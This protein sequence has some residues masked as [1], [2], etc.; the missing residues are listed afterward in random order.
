[1]TPH[2]VCPDTESWDTLVHNGMVKIN[3]NNSVYSLKLMEEENKKDNDSRNSIYE[4][5]YLMVPGIAEENVGA[6]VTNLKDKLTE[7]GAVIISDEFPKMMELAYEMARSIKNKKQKF[8][9]GYFGWVKFDATTE[10]AVVI[11]DMLDKNEQLI[12]YLLVKT[13]REN[14]MSQKRVYNKSEGFKRKVTPKEEALPINEETIDKDIE[15]LMV[16]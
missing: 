13:V 10:S 16:E 11:K 15:A 4:V 6:E 12:R 2:L 14:T 1:M 8:T 9:Y 5:G 7:L 3:N